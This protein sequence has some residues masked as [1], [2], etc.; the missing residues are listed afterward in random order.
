MWTRS[1][2]SAFEFHRIV[3]DIYPDGVRLIRFVVSDF[4]GRF[5]TPNWGAKLISLDEVSELTELQKKQVELNSGIDGFRK[6]RRDVSPGEETEVLKPPIAGSEAPGVEER[7]LRHE[8]FPERY[9]KLASLVERERNEIYELTL[10]NAT[11]KVSPNSGTIVVFTSTKTDDDIALLAKHISE[12]ISSRNKML[13]SLDGDKNFAPI[14]LVHVFFFIIYPVVEGNF[15][16][17]T[18]KPLTKMNDQ[19]FYSVVC[20]EAGASLRPILHRIILSIY[21]LASTT[22]T[23]IP[24]KEEAQQGQSI[25][26]D[27]EVFHPRRSHQILRE[28]GFITPESRLRAIVSPGDYETVK[29]SWTTPSAKNRWNYFPRCISALPITPASVNSR[30]SVCLTSFLLGGRNVMLEVRLFSFFFSELLH[31]SVLKQNVHMP[32]EVEPNVLNAFG[33]L[34]SDASSSSSGEKP[35]N[36]QARKQLLRLTRYWPTKLKDAFIYNIPKVFINFITFLAFF[37]QFP[38]CISALPITPASVNSRPSVCLTSF[39]LG[40]RNVMLEVLKQNVHM[41]KEVEPNVSQNF[42]LNFASYLMF[43]YGLPPEFAFET[44]LDSYVLLEKSIMLKPSAPLRTAD[45]ITLMK[46]CR[47]VVPTEEEDASSSSSSEK[48]SN[49]Q[50]RKQLLRLTRYWPTKLKDAFIYNIPK[51]FDPLLTLMRRSELST[52]D[53]SK[54]RECISVIMSHKDSKEPLTSRTI[55]CVKFK[56][57][58]N[59]EEQFRVACEELLLH[60]RNYVNHSERHLEVYNMFLQV[61]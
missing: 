19:V 24:M 43:F 40:G 25:N 18:P 38:R 35:S 56:N 37:F 14:A 27:V 4:V 20:A 28:L 13:K 50:A 23:S 26:Y 58:L 61:F 30:P 47:V 5:L 39:L 41:P 29:L 9:E 51:K 3:E 60:L 15:P 6:R 21:D 8:R 49:E 22:V 36:E 32:K 34:L 16:L 33:N 17:P 54:C 45:F 11:K 1:V 44:V 7:D 52:N 42:F 57:P 12:V 10:E 48:P 53:V 2:E 59:R 46:E 55:S 31:F